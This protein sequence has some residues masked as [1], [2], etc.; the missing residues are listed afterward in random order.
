[1]MRFS[2]LLRAGLLCLTTV[3]LG[4]CA[5]TTG[6]P[7]RPKTIQ[8]FM[9][10]DARPRVIAHR[11]FSGQA[12][13]NTMAAFT[14][15]V[16][17]KADMMELDVLLTRDG[18]IVV[19]HDDTL[20][21]TTN[22]TGRVADYTYEELRQFDA[23]TWFHPRFE[24]E[25]IPLLRDVLAYSRSKIL[26]NIEIKTEAYSPNTFES[27]AAKVVA[28]VD[29]LGMRDQV[30]I[31]SFDSR[32]LKQ[33]RQ[34]DSA[35]RMATLYDK[36]V[37][38]ELRPLVIVAN[39]G[40]NGFNLGKSEV[41]ARVVQECHSQLIPVSVYTVNTREMMDFILGM[42]VDAIFTDHPD[43]MIGLLKEKSFPRMKPEEIARAP[44]SAELKFEAR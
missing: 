23:G 42:G 15:A 20:E 3:L 35:I 25:R 38:G 29:E 31:S 1:M 19:I 21:R 33:V 2:L 37:H 4:G 8:E 9:A 27:I 18:Q 17:V 6:A 44:K 36:D 32:I 40:S 24:G 28:L 7:A 39:D 11:G 26:V 41:S 10:L 34:L 13:E 16:K 43:I 5:M 22:G 30:I 14:R 12:P